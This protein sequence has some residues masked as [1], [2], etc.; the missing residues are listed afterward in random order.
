MSRCC[1]SRA[2]INSAARDCCQAGHGSLGPVGDH[3]L[4]P[5]VEAEVDRPRRVDGPAVHP[6]S[7]LAD[8][9]RSAPG[10]RG[11]SRCP[12]RRSSR[13]RRNGSARNHCVRRLGEQHQRRGRGR[14]ARIRRSATQEKRHHPDRGRPAPAQPNVVE[15]LA[16]AGA[17]PGRRTGS[18][19]WSRSPARPARPYV[20]PRSRAAGAG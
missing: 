20:R 15:Q 6:A 14:A 1:P 4:D 5:E 7:R 9:A 16:P 8:L 13:C 12:D 11:P 3:G 10:A 2:D 17:R 19:A 18:G